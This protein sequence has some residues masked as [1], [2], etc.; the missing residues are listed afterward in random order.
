MDKQRFLPIIYI[1]LVWN[2]ILDVG[3]TLNIT[4]LLHNVA[5]GQYTSLPL[6][7]RFAYAVQTLL[8][9]YQ[10]Y[11]V[12]QLYRRNGAWSRASHLLA[13]IFLVLAAM[14][15]LVNSLSKSQGERWN[16]IASTVIAIGF[17]VFAN[18][19]FRPT[20]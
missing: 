10:F 16:A 17:Y 3:A 2:L 12:T 9:I 14:N 6:S 4:S 1:A 20:H 8:V 19:N 11:F 13:R 15:A 5:N 18:I 7:L